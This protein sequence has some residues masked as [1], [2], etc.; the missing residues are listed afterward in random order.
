MPYRS[1]AQSG[2]IHAQASQ[3]VPWAKKFVADSH[4]TTVPKI[5]R[6]PR[7]KVKRRAT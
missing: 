7:R 6:V 4:G 1:L 5:R 2:Y 3:G